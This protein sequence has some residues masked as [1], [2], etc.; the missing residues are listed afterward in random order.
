[1]KA[2]FWQVFR[3]FSLLVLLLTWNTVRANSDSLALLQGQVSD[4]ISKRAIADVSIRIEGTQIGTTTNARGEFTLKIPQEMASNELL[5]EFSHIAYVSKKI[6]LKLLKGKKI[7]IALDPK[8]VQ[9]R[10]FTMSGQPSMVYGNVNY[11]LVDYEL[12]GEHLMLIGYEKRLGKS[13]LLV[14]GENGQLLYTHRIPGKPIQL[15]KDCCN[16]IYIVTQDHFFRVLLEESRLTLVYAD[17]NIYNRLVNTCV[18]RS[19]TH[20]FFETYSNAKQSKRFYHLDSLAATIQPIWEMED[21]ETFR[22]IKEEGAFLAAG[23]YRTKHGKE[24]DRI[25]TKTILYRPLNIPLYVLSDTVYVF[26]HFGN[27]IEALNIWGEPLF[28][29]PVSYHQNKDWGET[30]L[31]DPIQQKLYTINFHNGHTEILLLDPISGMTESLLKID[32]RYIEKIQIYDGEVFFL[33]RPTGSIQ[34][35]ALYKQLL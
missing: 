1:M 20:Y 21:R 18:D 19:G 35:K 23:V 24:M 16:E 17:Q 28:S 34:R 22:R 32:F 6:P 4:A 26:N 30:V 8:S 14:L 7:N 27:Q 11:Q 29:T 10:E 3:L 31:K 13:T 12:L 9:I 5:L 15:M 2:V 25:Y 33:Y